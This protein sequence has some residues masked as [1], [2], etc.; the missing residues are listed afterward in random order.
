MI[1]SLT[2]FFCLLFHHFV[3]ASTA[4]NGTALEQSYNDSLV[5]LHSG[6]WH[7]KLDLFSSK[8]TAENDA[9]WSVSTVTMPDAKIRI[10]RNPVLLPLLEGAV[11][12]Y[13]AH[14]PKFG[15]VIKG[16]GKII[17][18][19]DQGGTLYDTYDKVNNIINGDPIEELGNNV[20]SGFNQLGTQVNSGFQQTLNGIGIAN[21]QIGQVNSNVKNMHGD[22]NRGF[23]SVNS[24]VKN[25]HGDMNRGFNSVNS[26]VKNMHGDMNR[27]FNS[28]NSN[29]KNMHGD[30]NRGFNSVN[31]NVKNMHGDMNRGFNSVNSNVK[32]MH[33]DMNRGFNSVNSNVKNMHG[34]MNRGF[35]SVN[36]NVKNMHGDMNRGFSYMGH[37]LDNVDR[38]IYEGRVEN[39]GLHG[40][41]HSM[42]DRNLAAMQTGF[43]MLGHGIDR[44]YEAI[45]HSTIQ[46]NQQFACTQY[47]I[48]QGRYENAANFEV[49]HK[50]QKVTQDLVNDGRIENA[51]NFVV[52]QD[53][54]NDGRIESA[55]NFQNAYYLINKGREENAKSFST[56]AKMNVINFEEVL[57]SRIESRYRFDV[58][59]GLLD[60]N[61]DSSLEGRRE[62]G[63]Y[64]NSTVN[65]LGK[66]RLENW[67]YFNNTFY[68]LQ[69]L[70]NESQKQEELARLDRYA[71]HM[72]TVN[73]LNATNAA[74][75][76]SIGEVKED[77]ADLSAQ[78]KR[79]FDEVI[80]LIR[81][82]NLAPMFSKLRTFFEYFHDERSSTYRLNRNDLFAKLKN[83]NG[84]LYYLTNAR[85][86]HQTDSL[87]SLLNDIIN[88]PASIPK[89]ETDQ[90]AFT[91]LDF[92]C[93]GTK[94]YVE[95][96]NFVLK[97][98]AFM[99]DKYYAERD[100]DNFNKYHS[101]FVIT[102]D[103]FHKSIGGA[104]TGMI[105]KV[106]NILN[107]VKTL[108]KMSK[109]VDQIFDAFRE[110]KTIFDEVS[111][112]LP[113][114]IP[115]EL[116]II[117]NFDDS[118][119]QTPVGE[120]KSGSKV[121]YAM[122]FIEN[123]F[124]SQ[125]GP[126]SKPYT[127]DDKA[128]P[129]FIIP[130]IHQSNVSVVLIFRRFNEQNSELVAILN[131]STQ[132]Q[133][134]RD[135]DRD[136]Y[137]SAGVHNQKLALP[138]VETLLS[139]NA[140]KSRRFEDGECAVHAA[141][142]A[143]NIEIVGKLI[144]NDTGIDELD[145]DGN[146]PLHLSLVSSYSDKLVYQAV[147]R[148]I[149]M[150]ADVNIANNYGMFPL[151]IATDKNNSALVK[152]L[153][154]TPSINP[155][156][157]YIDNMTAL[158]FSAQFGQ[159]N[160]TEQLINHPA[161]NQNAQTFDG[162]TPLQLAV[163]HGQ[164]DVIKLLCSSSKVKVNAKAAENMTALHYSALIGNPNVTTA[165]LNN[166]GAIDVN[167]Q[168]TSGITPLHFSGGAGN[169]EVLQQL[170]SRRDVDIN[171]KTENGWSPLHFAIALRKN[172][173][174]LKL[175]SK[176]SIE[177]NGQTTDT[178]LTP[179]HLA[180]LNSLPD[181]FDRLF[182]LDA[183]TNIRDNRNFTALHYAAMFSDDYILKKLLTFNE[184]IDA[185]GENGLTPLQVAVM[186]QNLKAIRFLLNQNPPAAINIKTQTGKTAL[187]LAATFNNASIVSELIKKGAE[188]DLMDGN[189]RT[190]LY[191]ALKYESTDV[192]GLL[193]ANGSRLNVPYP[194]NNLTLLEIAMKNGDEIK[195]LT[196]MEKLN[197]TDETGL[198]TLELASLYNIK[199]Y[200]L[201]NPNKISSTA[202]FNI[203]FDLTNQTLK[204]FN[205]QDF[206][207]LISRIGINWRNEDQKTLLHVAAEHGYYEAAKALIKNSSQLVNANNKYNW[208]PLHG[209]SSNNH[210]E[211]VKLLLSNGA[212]VNAKN[213]NNQTALHRA[214]FWGHLEVV[215]FLVEK[216][217][218]INAKDEAG[219]TSLHDAALSGHHE[220]VKLLV[221]SGA[222][223]NTKTK[224]GNTPLN[225]VNR[226]SQNAK[227][228]RCLET[229][230][231]QS[232]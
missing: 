75:Q 125:I 20:K 3:N 159:E 163:I 199:S 7:G 110:V 175:L 88:Q 53:L 82:S 130:S 170:I 117:L 56:L 167:A 166:C 38:S 91:A 52:T 218:D 202:I 5:L 186:H 84:P 214:A 230:V 208:Y 178:K 160:I 220:V 85:T 60:R 191:L 153:L 180:S 225:F 12:L 197:L 142:R 138:L 93:Y 47:L 120:W 83:E 150:E 10:K 134:F 18:V 34:D 32:N 87:H 44:N 168:T 94:V 49:S 2:I 184:K 54:I 51:I 27:G 112:L 77:I 55:I 132:D 158:H 115:D 92:L 174:A 123:D 131:P 169:V 114:K 19:L 119:L 17:E 195:I 9:S 105:D 127:I 108:P 177:I 28:V 155:N 156:K 207:Q 129:S 15:K 13:A 188:V 149:E 232:N 135:I 81:Q 30:M 113:R 96:M 141:A 204:N 136:L 190:A 61:Y 57:R 164:L 221:E 71:Y 143:L 29:V 64:F 86:P 23:N 4:Q 116:P 40:Q 63:S 121:K 68:F 211:I 222:D 223:I 122:Q 70:R 161:T 59:N 43:S 219:W 58:V 231:C 62:A 198:N 179:L 31:S 37:R 80:E 185:V 26:N 66:S 11:G 97:G 228:I 224:I 196:T 45:V 152:L 106:G 193:T 41:T 89:N 36:S 206:D 205:Q 98:Y 216:G 183:Q 72:S 140:N 25:M 209:A 69:L 104:S 147:R 165:L 107:R 102:F 133:Q 145:A 101:K 203:T 111:K 103:G 144:E 39:R 146:T 194:Q 229:K 162:I 35:N 67:K 6:I 14:Q 226:N 173:T 154:Q 213:N 148:L 118:Q 182:R 109:R 65:L 171:A 8:V 16:V 42:L 189:N 139:N 73:L 22:M 78:I 217:A 90:L 187:H 215:K 201:D 181:V 124:L 33:G 74:L 50:L 200:L 128:G 79:S 172:K 210:L 76:K 126:W 21:K 1:W 48:N 24:N 100:L 192:V 176:E 227:L 46:M 151:L 212:D 157:R 99:T 137:N 95:V